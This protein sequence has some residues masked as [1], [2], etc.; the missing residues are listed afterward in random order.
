MILERSSENRFSRIKQPKFC[1]SFWYNRPKEEFF[2]GL[3]HHIIPEKE[4]DLRVCDESYKPVLE[5]EL[6]VFRQA[7]DILDRSPINEFFLK[8]ERR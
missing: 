4:K 3:L 1:L 6:W 7:L 5:S 2:F 8:E